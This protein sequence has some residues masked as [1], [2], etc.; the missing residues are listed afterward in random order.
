MVV[1]S[2]SSQRP[3]AGGDTTTVPAAVVEM[4]ALVAFPVIESW[5]AA[6]LIPL[7]LF[8]SAQF[9]GAN[10]V[11]L[12]VY[13]ALGGALFL[14][15]LQLQQSLGYSALAAGLAFLPFTVIMLLLS[16][17]IGALAQKVGPR[18]PIDHR[19]HVDGGAAAAGAVCGKA[20]SLL[21]LELVEVVA[22]LLS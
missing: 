18:W 15:A 16:S 1:S 2:G 14:L 10:L 19:P 9:A 11:T 20:R 22:E 12:A 13:T 3:R 5:A 4:L 6:P 8:R 17:R 21:V 7:S